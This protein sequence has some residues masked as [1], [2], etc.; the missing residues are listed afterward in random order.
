MLTSSKPAAINL[1]YVLRLALPIAILLIV[2]IPFGLGFMFMQ[3][4]TFTGC[5]LDG[6]PAA[7]GIPREEITFPSSE[8]DADY[9]GYFI[10]GDN[11]ATIIVVPTLQ[12]G[13]G[14]RMEEIV[15]YHE[16]GYNVLSYRARTCF[17]A[18]HSLG[19][20]EVT[21]V[22]DALAYLR[23]RP[24]VD[25]N[26]VAI[27]G[28]SAGG[29]TALMALARY[30][31]L[32]TAVAHGGYH[33]FSAVVDV[34]AAGMGML[35][36]Y[37]LTTG[38]DPS[39]LNPKQA[40]VDAAPRPVLLVYGSREVSLPGARIMQSLAPERV[41]LWEVPGAG[42]GDYVSIIGAE[43]YSREVFG[44]LDAVFASGRPS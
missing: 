36:A 1:G 39:V 19:Y 2:G 33:D 16:G 10:A 18:R 20:A 9:A 43:A 15:I 34:S 38:Y 5:A 14:D 7:R 25:M 8:F 26:R 42:H 24:G 28:F 32:R 21:A 6:D 17:G 31:E 30:P 11:G 12:T 37:R 13:R 27:H 40:V 29:A 35:S 23:T 3:G 41:R 22:G 4:L 44:F